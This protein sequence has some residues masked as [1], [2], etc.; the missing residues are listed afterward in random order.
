MILLS[1]KHLETVQLF[2]TIF[3][4]LEIIAL[5]I[6]EKLKPAYATRIRRA[7]WPIGIRHQF[8]WTDQTEGK[9]EEELK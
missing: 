2:K 4:T 9:K 6:T 5:I 1:F 3:S 8:P 7:K